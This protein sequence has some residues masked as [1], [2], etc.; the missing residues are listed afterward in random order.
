[1]R[2]RLL[3][4]ALL[5]TLAACNDDVRLG[6]LPADA[7]SDAVLDGSSDAGSADAQDGG[8]DS[9]CGDVT[10]SN[11]NC[12]RCGH[13]CNGQAC[14]AGKCA[15]VLLASGLSRPDW[16]AVDATH[17]YFTCNGKTGFPS[18]ENETDKVDLS[19][20]G[21][22]VLRA[23]TGKPAGIVVDATSVYWTSKAYASAESMIRKID[24][25]GGSVT[26]VANAS[27][28]D[29]QGLARDGTE[30]FWAG[31]TAVRRAM[32]TDNTTF[33]TDY[34]TG[35]ASAWG[36]AVSPTRLYVTSGGPLNFSVVDRATKGVVFQ[37]NLAGT[38]FD[39]V[40]SGNDVYV[41]TGVALF[42]LDAGG[43]VV[44]TLDQGYVGGLGV[45]VD[46]ERVYWTTDKELRSR[47]R[48]LQG[49]LQVDAEYTDLGHLAL[50]GNWLY[51]TRHAAGEVRK[52]AR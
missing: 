31:N 2:P 52:I 13:S 28:G 51:F 44:A 35:L 47:R 22:T 34:L 29:A 48:D 41:A 50:D 38:A 12:G 23:E 3:A 16:L 9:G 1:M 49:G 21:F 39:V 17:V 10:S 6:A 7:S 36:V 27:L 32:T 18:Q 14:V 43:Q 5:G 15:S 19:G 26:P 8:A 20:N 46:A 24:K 40:V 30:L 42:Q 37:G 11:V 33:G 4:L 45:A 25:G